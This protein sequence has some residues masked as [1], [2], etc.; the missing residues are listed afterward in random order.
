MFPYSLLNMFYY[1]F[2]TQFVLLKKK[3]VFRF[4]FRFCIFLLFGTNVSLLI[5]SSFVFSSTEGMRRLRHIAW[6]SWFIAS[7]RAKAKKVLLTLQEG[8]QIIMIIFSSRSLHNNHNETSIRREPLT[9]KQNSVRCTKFK[10][11]LHP[12]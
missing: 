1:L 11:K 5:F 8:R 10:Y 2:S 7:L 3:I 12:R 6:A 9:L 4:H